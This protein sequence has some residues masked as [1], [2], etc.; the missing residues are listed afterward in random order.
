MKGVCLFK[1]Y[2]EVKC[3]KRY[4]DEFNKVNKVELNDH[5]WIFLSVSMLESS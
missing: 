5:F 3:T 1:L 2:T 4:N